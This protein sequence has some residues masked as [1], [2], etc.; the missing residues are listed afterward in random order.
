M[1]AEDE[2]V[3]FEYNLL[4]CEWVCA[5]RV[6]L[7]AVLTLNVNWDTLIHFF[8]WPLSLFRSF[9]FN[10]FTSPPPP[11]TWAKTHESRGP[12]KEKVRTILFSYSPPIAPATTLFPPLSSTSPSHLYTLISCSCL[13]CLFVSSQKGTNSLHCFRK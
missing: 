9:Y 1:C 12:L 6:L 2:H 5:S 7:C 4:M 10:I 3:V 11:S 8:C 13:V